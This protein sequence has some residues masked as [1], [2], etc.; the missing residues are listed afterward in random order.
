[1]KKLMM[2]LALLSMMALCVRTAVGGVLNYRTENL[3]G[4]K[5]KLVQV[6]GG[7]PSGRVVIPETY[8]GLTVTELGED[9]MDVPSNGDPGHVTEVVIPNTVTKI[10]KNAFLEAGL[11]TITIPA[12]VTE[13][14]CGA[15]SHNPST[16]ITVEAGNRHFKTYDNGKLLVNEDNHR[17]L[18]CIQYPG[19]VRIPDGVVSIEK[20]AFEV[21]VA[22]GIVFPSTLKRIETWAFSSFSGVTEFDFSETQLEKVDSYAFCVDTLR[23]VKFPATLKEI[24]KWTFVGPMLT[25]VYYA[26][27]VPKLGSNPEAESD[28]LQMFPALAN[29]K[30]YGCI[31]GN[32]DW[33]RGSVSIN[34]NVTTYVQHGQG[35]DDVVRQ[36]TWQGVPIAYAPGAV[37]YRAEPNYLDGGITLTGIASGTPSGMLV[38]PSTYDGRTVTKVGVEGWD[39]EQGSFAN[40]D[41]TG[42]VIPEGVTEL[43]Y[44]AFHGCKKLT[45]VTLPSTL[46]VI[47]DN[48]FEGCSALKS[49]DLPEGLQKVEHDFLHDTAVS[50][51]RIPSTLVDI[52][53][54][55]LAISSGRKFTVAEGNPRYRVE[56]GYIYDFV[57][58]VVFMRADY[59]QKTFVIPDGAVRIAECCFG[60]CDGGNITIPDSVRRIDYGVFCGCQGLTVTFLGEKPEVWGGD[61]FDDSTNVK[62]YV[63]PGMGWENEIRT[64]KWQGC[65]LIRAPG[66]GECRFDGNGSP[67]S[68]PSVAMKIDLVCKLPKCT[69]R[70]PSDMLHF[71]GWA[72][73]NGKRY[74]DEMLVFGLGDV[75]MTAIWE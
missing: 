7:H 49:L 3:G 29:L 69:L 33:D 74:D 43:S 36:G 41:I 47:R 42:L 51:L 35:W 16:M 30:P 48:C 61:I 75:T 67:D 18:T 46:K 60:D 21:V 62:V 54:G 8:N 44:G 40:L 9:L 65:Q 20:T 68:M 39:H 1:M 71:G 34:F 15:F 72:C 52:E 25:K 10:D 59:Y 32:L 56:N 38:L 64:G 50:T 37:A 26:G 45:S 63:L 66:Y 70:S 22:D 4:G 19:T 55:A 17:L 12:S 23:T 57:D 2:V 24:G 28:A 5:V 53:E 13:I 73:S 11:K 6:I 58:N 31:Y 27:G 14:G